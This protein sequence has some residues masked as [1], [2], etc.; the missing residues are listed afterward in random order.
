[1]FAQTVY[2]GTLKS[3]ASVIFSSGFRKSREQDE[4]L[5]FGVYFFEC[6]QDARA[7]AMQMMSQRKDKNAGIVISADLKCKDDVDF[8]DLDIDDNMRKMETEMQ[9][10]LIKCRHSGA[11]NIS[12]KKLRCLACNFYGEKYGIKIFAFSFTAFDYNIIGFP[13]KTRKQRQFCVRDINIIYNVKEAEIDYA[14]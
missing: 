12:S 14:I 7:W 1:M 3:A 5:G 4:W 2:H 10:V 8:Y 9:K 11:P 6:Y 13:L